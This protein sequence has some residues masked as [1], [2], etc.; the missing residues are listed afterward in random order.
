MSDFDSFGNY[1][2]G[3]FQEQDSFQ[4]DQPSS[5]KQ[6]LRTSL[7]PVTIKQINESTQPFP[8][9]EFQI[10]GVS[11]NMVSF[12]GVIRKI[13]NTSSAI[14][15]TIEDGTGSIAIRRWVDANVT[16]ADEEAN[17][18]FAMQDKYVLVT[19]ALKEFNQKKNIQNTT[20]REIKDHNELVYHNLSAIYT[21]IKAQGITRSNKDELFVSDDAGASQKN[22]GSLDDMV[23]KVVAEN[24][25]V[26]AE[27]VP[28]RLISEKLKISSDDASARCLAL[29]EAGRIYSAYDDQAFLSV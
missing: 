13:E 10:N 6:Q 21:H 19:G 18:Y 7:T 8:D 1:G 3:G 24:S 15:L 12:C 14:V 23:Y 26:M 25:S 16:T 9:A 2:D 29:V 20:I 5:Q 28:I 17:L 4:N 27:G 11:L 22:L